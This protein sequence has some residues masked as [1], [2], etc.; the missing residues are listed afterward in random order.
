MGRGFSDM[1]PKGTKFDADEHVKQLERLI[2]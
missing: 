1:P 2:E